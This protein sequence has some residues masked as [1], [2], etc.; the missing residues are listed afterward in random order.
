MAQEKPMTEQ[1]VQSF[2]DEVAKAVDTVVTPD[3]TRTDAIKAVCDAVEGMAPKKDLGGM[4]A[5][6]GLGDMESMA[7]DAGGESE[8]GAGE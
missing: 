3:M 5:E 4:G 7:E 6:S 2:K 1:E 8:Q